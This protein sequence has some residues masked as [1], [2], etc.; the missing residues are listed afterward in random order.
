M[1]QT[2]KACYKI[3]PCKDNPMTKEQID[4]DPSMGG[5][6]AIV[7]FSI[8]FPPNGGRSELIASYDGRTGEPLSDEELFKCFSSL[9][10]RL[11]ESPTLGPGKKE[12][13]KAVFEKIKEAILAARAEK[14][15]KPT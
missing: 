6:D 8:I 14:E 9:A 1:N 13:C 2:Y 3:F 10:H 4:A 5:A 7:L 11:S 15:K 12:F